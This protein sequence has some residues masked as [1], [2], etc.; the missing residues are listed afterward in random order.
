MRPMFKMFM[1]RQVE[2]AEPD[3]GAGWQARDDPC[4]R[5]VEA[6]ILLLEILLARCN[7]GVGRREPM[8]PPLA[9]HLSEEG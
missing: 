1:G 3:P 8:L 2:P 7:H 4:R 5:R 9:Q 6:L